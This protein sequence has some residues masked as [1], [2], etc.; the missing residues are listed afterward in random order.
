VIEL[1]GEEASAEGAARTLDELCS[2]EVISRHSGQRFEGEA[3]EEYR[4]RHALVRD[5]AYA[6]LTPADR[7]LGHRLAGDWLE[8]MGERDAATLAEHFELGGQPERA[9]GWHRRAAEQSFEGLD[10]A[11]VIE[12]AERGVRCGATGEVKGALMALACE[13][14][15][16][17]AE[18]LDAAARGAE[19]I[20]LSPRGS[21]PWCRAAAW[22]LH[23]GQGSRARADALGRELVASP[24]TPAVASAHGQ[25][26]AMAVRALSFAGDYARSRE[27]LA[28]IEGLDPSRLSGL[29]RGYIA[30]AA[31][32]LALCGDGDPWRALALIDE[33][34]AYFT[35]S[36]YYSAAAIAQADRA[37]AL[38][39]AGDYAAAQ[40]ALESALADALRE[41]NHFVVTWAR[42]GLSD[43]LSRR[44]AYAEACEAARLAEA[45]YS[46]GG[47]VPMAGAC[48]G[49]LAMAH[50]RAGDFEAA[51]KTAR[52]AAAVRP[53]GRPYRAEILA[54]LASILVVR[55]RA[56]EAL[57]TAESA[58]ELLA[59]MG[60][61]SQMGAPVLLAHAEALA[62]VGRT[63]E[64]AKAI[65]KARARLLERAA[66]CPDPEARARF[67]SCISENARTLAL[68][69]AW[70]GA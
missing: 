34:K 29:A 47:S 51:E 68:A 8:R 13:A 26:C 52:E 59:S 48:R 35:E 60:E 65:A 27:Y 38:A 54:S 2:R 22:L 32:Y 43:V 33:S 11:A 70:I 28:H 57:K 18:W 25:A 12:R 63:E 10:F 67:L 3:Q 45:T 66:R 30:S 42:M 15:A 19:A 24:P 6:M 36:R 5:A 23:V 49:R 20:A 31:S 1:L 64:A 9:V 41:G 55:G 69:E 62:A 39:G 14:H 61:G 50:A 16:F 17:R 37:M 53:M 4:F 7:A 56:D 40:R 21:T 58:L 44:G 46:Q